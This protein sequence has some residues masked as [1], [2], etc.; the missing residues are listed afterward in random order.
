MRDAGNNLIL[1]CSRIALSPDHIFRIREYASQ[2]FNWE[3]VFRTASSHG[4][5]PLL[6]THLKKSCPDLITAD[7]MNQLQKMYVRN[8]TKNLSVSAMLLKILN[9]FTAKGILAVPLK[10]PVL[11]EKVYGDISLRQFS[12]L[13]I[14]VKKEDVI[15][16][17][18]LL[19]GCGYEPE[20]KL[21]GKRGSQYLEFENSISFFHNK[22]GPS[23]DL[24]WEMTGRYLLTPLYLEA[25]EGK[26]QQSV[27]LNQKVLSIPDDILLIYL[28]LHGTSHCWDR[29]EWLCC[30]VEMVR[31]QNE[32]GLFEIIELAGEIGCK[33][34]L[35]LGLYLGYDLLDA[36]LPD[37]VLETIVNDKE[38]VKY[39]KKVKQIIF[40]QKT[41][42]IDVAK[43]RFS[44]L[45]IQIRDTYRDR[46]NY[47]VYLYTMPTIKEWIKCPLPS[48]LTPLYRVI[49]PLRLGIA[50][51]S[52]K[53]S[54]SKKIK[55]TNVLDI[56]T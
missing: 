35:Y 50:F 6:Y 16:V 39:G 24:H 36:A 15:K 28:C 47:A 44:P 18:N 20:L 37:K 11:A 45:H 34:L 13:D 54:L 8:Y 51:L 5:A 2:I 53:N 1:A 48:W 19:V 42:S 32:K 21:D 9:L 25:F 52:G 12:D 43:W 49:R 38:V 10:G 55:T 23:I 7:V 26:L 27:F 29:F 22:C 40:N 30:F 56:K 14:L 41:D 3:N 4:I 17:Q 46:L 33:R 31:K